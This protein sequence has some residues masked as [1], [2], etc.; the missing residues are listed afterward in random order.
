M[1]EQIVPVALERHRH[2]KVRNT[3]QFDFASRFHI[4]Y[5]TLH[6]F[7]RAAATYPIVFLEDKPNDGFRPVVL[8]G[9]QPGENLFVGADGSWNA[10]YIPAMIRRYPFALSKGSEEGR[11]VVCV[12]EAS[13]LLSD[14]EGAPM[15]DDKGEPTQVIENVKRYLA[16]LQQMDRMTQEFSRFL[17]SQN[18][19]TPLNMRVNATAQAR[20]ITGC[21]VINEERLGAFSDSLFLEVRHKGYLPAM[22]AHLM[23]L[24]Q[25]ERLVQLSKAQAQPLAAA[26]ASAADAEVVSAEVEAGVVAEVP[27]EVK[28]AGR[29]RRNDTPT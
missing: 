20:N 12:D 10:S 17:Q 29:K 11:F 26:P 8:M 2:K 25:I 19:L 18:L 3:T 4:A 15:F 23:S 22:Y 21:Y 9:L 7:A 14:T 16:E 24:P 1:F 27:S 28:P 5:V 6:E 13:T